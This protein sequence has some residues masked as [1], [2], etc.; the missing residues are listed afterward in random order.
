MEGFEVAIICMLAFLI[1]LVVGLYVAMFFLFAAYWPD[2]KSE[3]ELFDEAR[4]SNSGLY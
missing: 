4:K 3:K 2:H 1:V